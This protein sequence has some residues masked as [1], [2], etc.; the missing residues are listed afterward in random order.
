M[1]II[2]VDN[3][4]RFRTENRL[5]FGTDQPSKYYEVD[6]SEKTKEEK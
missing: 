4:L 5:V 6:I 2:V 1:L 3:G